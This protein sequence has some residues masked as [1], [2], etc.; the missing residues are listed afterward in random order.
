MGRSL[1]TMDAASA[2]ARRR[3]PVVIAS[4]YG[5]VYAV[6]QDNGQR[7]YIADALNGSD[8]A[9]ERSVDGPWSAVEVTPASRLVSQFLIRQHID[10]VSRIFHVDDAPA[11]HGQ[12]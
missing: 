8:L 2:A 6:L 3:E 1:V 9:Y 5:P 10:E 7:L 4:S 12:H 11:H